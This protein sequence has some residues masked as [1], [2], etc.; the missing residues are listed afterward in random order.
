MTTAARDDL[1][2]HLAPFGLS[3][4]RPG[5][6][7]VIETVLTGKDCLCVMPT[8]GGKSLCY[9]LP[10]IAQGG[11]TLVISPLI[12]LMKDQVDALQARGLS[13]TFINSSLSP[14]E[15]S[16]RLAR[17][18][19]GEYR[20]VYVVPER[21]RSPR[22]L[23]ALSRCELRLLAVDEAHCISEWGHDFRPDYARLGK[24]RA[25]LGKP[26][27]IALTATATGAVR[28]DIV[29]LLDLSEPEIFITGFARP[30]LF[31]SVQTC[32]TD[33]D[34]DAALFRFLAENRGSGIVYASTRKRCEELAER[35]KAQCGRSTTIYHAGL[36]PE[37]R[38]AAQDEF[39]QGRTE[40]A[41]AT[42]AFG[43]GI[44]KSDIRFVVHYNLPG[45]LEAYYQEAGR[46]G[47]DGQ[48]AACLLL[49][50]S[51]DR[52]IHEFFIES[53]YPSRQVVRSVYDFLCQLD[54]NP[55]EMT[56]QELK[57]ELGLPIGGEGVGACEKLLEKA[58]VLD[59]LEAA[60]NTAAV[61]LNSNLSTLVDLLPQ[62]AKVKRRV[63]RAVEQL[64]GGTRNEWYYLQPRELLRT[65]TDMESGDLSRHLRE[66][67][68]LT[69]FDYV[70]PFRGRA[71]HMRERTRPFDSLEIDFEA[72]EKRK[73]AEYERVEHVLRF[74]RHHQCRQQQ[75]LHYFGERD[76]G[77]CGHCDNCTARDRGGRG[78]SARSAAGPMLDA[79]R[80][81]LSGVARVSQRRS[82]CGKQLLAKM[83][84]GSNDKQVVRMRLDKL[85]TF[86]LLSRLSQAE[87][88]QLIEALLLSGLL[89]Q[90]E[91]EPFR[92]VVQIT[93][94]GTEVMSGRAGDALNL[95]LSDE[96]WHK[97]DPQA[98][99]ADRAQ[100]QAASPGGAPL[101]VDG[102]L[103]AR[104]RQWRNELSRA[105]VVPAYQ[106]L[107]NASLEE[108]ARARPSTLEAL[109]NIKG[110]GPNKVRQYGETILELLG[111]A[112]AADAM[113]KAPLAE[114]PSVDAAPVAAQP[115][116]AEQV[117][118]VSDDQHARELACNAQLAEIGA[119]EV[120][121]ETPPPPSHYWTWRM[122]QAGFKPE[123]CAAARG[124]SLEMVLDHA[125]RA[126]D[127]GWPAEALW[128]LSA[129][130]ISQIEQV[131]GPSPPT[132]IRPL[133]AQLP[134]GTRY[135]EVQLVLKSR[136]N[137][138]NEVA[139]HGASGVEKTPLVG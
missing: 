31:Y 82:N 90:T 89:E 37:N 51:G 84:C 104:L 66:L 91:L 76:S 53:A 99:A 55:I 19:A 60:E 103:V 127:A 88:V 38:R 48:P 78:A 10:A 113:S 14:E 71:I 74:A 72:L 6:R 67:T 54:Q 32:S 56:Q 134:R 58:G 40:I 7:E 111:A 69:A 133:L 120:K 94:R 24:F 125:L 43:M 137:T 130:Q 110:I 119:D 70:P 4:F 11:L 15:L 86:G 128:F 20:L 27:T 13:A 126:A 102:E 61:R 96:L 105:Q 117:A 42:L 45:S 77:D 118:I 83:L 23:E 1:E 115:S 98:A 107:T 109:L 46:A 26:P 16:Q 65:L 9:Q 59:R 39:M 79:V 64:V 129:A 73:A 80:I 8:G 106:V 97:L 139:G 41:V 93:D 135:E 63:L 87:V 121:P 47:R 35:I 81:V 5:Q 101:A 3:S 108:L 132:R 123:E 28:T 57:Q 116:G 33:R 124:L 68:M 62:Q 136:S 95:A 22:F 100:R 44:D 17:M 114:A 25:Q 30:N 92:P 12:A 138:A 131:L 2:A 34:K 85:S 122:L 21:F 18:A 75:I 29:K 36:T 112:P 49:F 52:Q 50:G